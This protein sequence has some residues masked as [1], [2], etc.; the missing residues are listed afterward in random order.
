MTKYQRLRS[1]TEYVESEFGSVKEPFSK[2]ANK[3]FY[4]RASC[5]FA[6]ALPIINLLNSKDRL[7]FDFEC[8]KTLTKLL[9]D[10]DCFDGGKISKWEIA[11]GDFRNFYLVTEFAGKVLSQ[12]EVVVKLLNTYFVLAIQ[13][14]TI[15]N[16]DVLE[17]FVAYLIKDIS[18]DLDVDLQRSKKVLDRI[19]KSKN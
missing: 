16:K 19:F 12:T 15:N 2:T 17:A 1:L 7:N 13:D 8:N 6:S 5:I 3:V 10:W 11:E 4:L 14:E 18:E 9:R